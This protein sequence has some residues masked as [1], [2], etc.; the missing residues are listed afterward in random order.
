MIVPSMLYKEIYDHLLN[1]IQKVK[2]RTEYLLPKAIKE[3]K[4]VKKLPAWRWYEYTVPSTNNYYF[5][6]NLIIR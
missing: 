2:F 4:K 1:D 6:N 5:W 3:F